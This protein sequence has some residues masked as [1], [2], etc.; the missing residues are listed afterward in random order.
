MKLIGAFSF[1]TIMSYTSVCCLLLTF[2][3]LFQKFFQEHHQ[4][5]KQFVGPDL[6]PNCFQRLLVD[7]TKSPPARGAN[8]CSF[9]HAAL[10]LR[11]RKRKDSVCCH[12]H[13]KVLRMVL[14]PP[15]P[16]ANATS[17]LLYQKSDTRHLC[18]LNI[19]F[20]LTLSFFVLWQDTLSAA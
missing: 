19:G 6:G 8:T 15:T 11:V 20:F 12:L 5:A 13:L 16:P 4:S 17:T 18:Q 7:D 3:Q 9:S 1:Y 14:L 2:S 10:C